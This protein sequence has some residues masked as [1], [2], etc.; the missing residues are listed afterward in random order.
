MAHLRKICTLALIVSTLFTHAQCMRVH[1]GD[2][3]TEQIDVAT[4]DC[5]T[6]DNNEQH[7]APTIRTTST[8]RV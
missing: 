3:W 6:F 4:V 2:G 7:L 5:I 1:Y 8:L